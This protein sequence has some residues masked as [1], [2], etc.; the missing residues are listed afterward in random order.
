MAKKK[1][2]MVD[3]TFRAILGLNRTEE[4]VAAEATEPAAPAAAE[5]PQQETDE[6]PKKK[7]GRRKLEVEKKKS[8]TMS[9]LPSLYQRALDIAYEEGKTLSQVISELLTEYVERN[10]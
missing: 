1:E 4:D 5:R 8:F 2:V 6:K 9:L 7:T 3:D 10:S